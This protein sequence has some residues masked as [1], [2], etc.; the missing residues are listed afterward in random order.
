LND[1]EIKNGLN[2]IEIKNGLEIVGLGFAQLLDVA[3][4]QV[5][6]E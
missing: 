1:V 4:I 5:V 6:G 2:D 3:F